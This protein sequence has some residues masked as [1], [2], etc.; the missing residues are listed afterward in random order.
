MTTAQD[1]KDT[2]TKLI[3][4]ILSN[5]NYNFTDAKKAA[6]IAVTHAK[7]LLVKLE[8]DAKA[9]VHAGAI[10][11]EKAAAQVETAAANVK[12]TAVGVKDATAKKDPAAS[13]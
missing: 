9:A 8:E 12:K 10:V 2:A 4:G 13:I 1:I 7:A 11:V 6:D 3:T 5:P